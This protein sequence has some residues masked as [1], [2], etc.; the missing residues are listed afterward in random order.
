MR[1]SV[2]ALRR[3]GAVKLAK[4]LGQSLGFGVYGVLG[5]L[6]QAAERGWVC[7]SGCLGFKIT[8][9]LGTHQKHIRNTAATH[10]LRRQL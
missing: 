4:R 5:A 6:P 8:Y 7:V 2:A 1:V 9:A 10:L 3:C